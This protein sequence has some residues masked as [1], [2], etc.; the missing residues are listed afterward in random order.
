[1]KT[2][3]D[4]KPQPVKRLPQRTCMACRQIKAKRKLVRIVKTSTGEIK[5][6]ETG[7]ISGR[8]AYLCRLK[9]CWESGLKTNRVEYQLRTKLAQEDRENLEKYK[10]QL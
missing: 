1:M 10:E 8:G 6:D 3:I 4:P 7:R 9:E 2:S 5:I